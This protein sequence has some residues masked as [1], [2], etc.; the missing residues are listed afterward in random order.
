MV[1]HMPDFTM[2]KYQ[3][4]CQILKEEKYIFLTIKKYIELKEAERIPEKFAIIRH[5]VDR[6]LYNAIRMAEEEQR[7]GI[8]STFYIRYPGTFNPDS[9]QYISR[10]GHEIGY[11]YEVVSKN[12]GDMK[13]AFEQFIKEL[14]QFRSFIPVYTICMHGN[15]LSPYDNRTLW[16]TYHFEDLGIIAEA[17]LSL[18]DLRYF[19]D[20]G[21]TWAGNRAIYDTLSEW[22]PKPKLR[23][24]QDLISWIENASPSYL[25]LTVHPERWAPD[26]LRY[27]ASWGMDFVVNI[28]KIVIKVVQ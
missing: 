3:T 13:K 24:T 1:P 8:R 15:P 11:H 14:S 18:S 9:M 16:N 22:V 28:G 7:I 6:W 26:P 25:Y 20:T 23:S 17:Y 12:N 5:D 21:R 4:L 19:T 10:L 2:S 27:L